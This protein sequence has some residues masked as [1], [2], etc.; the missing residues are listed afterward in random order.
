MIPQPLGDFSEGPK[1]FENITKLKLNELREPDAS[2]LTQSLRIPDRNDS[3]DLTL[4]LQNPRNYSVDSLES[5]H[6]F[7]SGNSELSTSRKEKN[8]PVQELKLQTGLSHDQQTTYKLAGRSGIRQPKID[9]FTY[10]TL[11]LSY[12]FKITKAKSIEP[13]IDAI[14]FIVAGSTGGSIENDNLIIR[15]LI[16]WLL[17]SLLALSEYKKNRYASQK[18]VL[19]LLYLP[20]LI[21]PFGWIFTFIVYYLVL[22]VSLTLSPILE[23]RQ[24]L[25]TSEFNRFKKENELIQDLENYWQKT[26]NFL[27]KGFQ[28]NKGSTKDSQLSSVEKL[29]S[30]RK[31]LREAMA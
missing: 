1:P 22:A 19:I 30:A 31:R 10:F 24:I 12:I 27:R 28:K 8:Q 16:C 5:Y 14:A 18:I 4:N 17:I 6:T 7:K 9:Q 3:K 15:M 21:A 29:G 11:I 13:I 20:I 25:N 23:A 26:R 2:I